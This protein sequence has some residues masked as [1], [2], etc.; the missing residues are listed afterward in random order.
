MLRAMSL[1]KNTVASTMSSAVTMRLSGDRSIMALRICSTG[2]R[3]PGPG[4]R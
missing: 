2:C 4:R 1:E 3:A